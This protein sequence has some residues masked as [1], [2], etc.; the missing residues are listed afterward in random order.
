MGEGIVI[1]ESY[2]PFQD[3]DKAAED[4]EHDCTDIEPPL[5]LASLPKGHSLSKH[6]NDADQQRAKTDAAEGICDRSSEG[7]AS[8][9]RGHASRFLRAKVPAAVDAGYR[10][11]KG[12]SY[13]LRNPVGGKSDKDDEAYY[14]R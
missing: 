3:G 14:L 5:S 12:L 2:G 4:T 11:M 6:L 1:D 13:P 7:P 9:T 8:S 10:G